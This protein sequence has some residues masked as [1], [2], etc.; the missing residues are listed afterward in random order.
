M[1]K[2][3]IFDFDGVIV[4][5]EVYYVNSLVEYLKTVGVNATFDDCKTVVGQSLEDIGQEL[6]DRFDLKDSLEKVI[7]DSI[8]IF[9]RS[10]NILDFK[11]MEG[12]IEFLEK[13]KHKGIKMSVAS[14]SDYDYLYT[15]L[16]NINLRQYFDF[17]LSGTDFTKS[18][19]NPE[20]FNV[21]AQ[22]MGIDKSELMIIEDS[23]NGI[24][25]GLASGIYTVGLKASL[26]EQDTSL[27]DLE[28]KSFSQIEI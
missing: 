2:G 19:P 5:S 13:C 24:K 7:K 12:L 11:P 9:D 21:A 18:K 20:V 25:A 17:V 26:I 22:R 23:I 6:I 4:D 16:D 10:I 28:V 14:S 1:I 15:I 8:A 27:A 3:I